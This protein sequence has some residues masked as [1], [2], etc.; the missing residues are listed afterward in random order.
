MYDSLAV[1][2]T[3]RTW[4]HPMALHNHIPLLCSLGWFLNGSLSLRLVGQYRNSVSCDFGRCAGAQRSPPPRLWRIGRERQNGLRQS[5]LTS[6]QTPHLS[7]KY[8]LT[9]P[10][11]V[12]NWRE[13]N[14]WDSLK[15]FFCLQVLSLQLL[16]I[17]QFG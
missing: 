3:M 7:P 1:V 11:N 17:R 8:F 9:S 12:Y 14:G 4:L 13:S 16:H 6:L 10:L 5:G 15:Q 2:Q